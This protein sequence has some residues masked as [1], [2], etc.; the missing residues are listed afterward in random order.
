[1]HLLSIY[2]LENAITAVNNSESNQ[3]KASIRGTWSFSGSRSIISNAT[4]ACQ[5]ETMAE[6]IRSGG[7]VG[8]GGTIYNQVKGRIKQRSPCP[9]LGETHLTG[10][11]RSEGLRWDCAWFVPEATV[12]PE[13]LIV[14]R[15]LGAR[16]GR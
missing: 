6:I 7:L 15:G 4:S 14:G 8:V 2:I 13:L 5:V 12:P 10:E 3:H 9:C 16:R 11:L 1:M